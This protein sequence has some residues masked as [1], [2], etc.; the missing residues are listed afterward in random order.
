MGSTGRLARDWAEFDSLF[1]HQFLN[2]SINKCMDI[3]RIKQLAGLN[4]GKRTV[5][6][7][8]EYNELSVEELLEQISSFADKYND[9][10]LKMV[11][12]ALQQKLR[13]SSS[14]EDS[15][16]LRPQAY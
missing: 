8:L 14:P 7:L 1:L 10:E 16:L 3:K 6:T 5:E 2:D 13:Q 11:V 12:A 4:E 15:A 9:Q